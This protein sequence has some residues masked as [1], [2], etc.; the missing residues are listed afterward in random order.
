VH[1]A[2]HLS[3]EHG[4]LVA[5]DR[6]LE[7]RLSGCRLARPEQAEKAAQEEIEE[8]ADHGAA[9]SHIEAIWPLCAC[10]RVLL[11]HGIE[12]LTGAID[13]DFLQ[14][15]LQAAQDAIQEEREHGRSLTDS[16][17][18]RQR[19]PSTARSSLFTPT[20][21][22]WSFWTPTPDLVSGSAAANVLLQ[23]RHNLQELIGL[24]PLV[25]AKTFS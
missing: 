17:A 2:L 21:Y 18:S 1:R 24:R 12:H 10:D 5:Q 20:G 8:R 3:A 25:A 22:P 19:R 11:P 6:N 9:L 13:A 4:E 16:Q 7:L 23:G 14:Q 15:V